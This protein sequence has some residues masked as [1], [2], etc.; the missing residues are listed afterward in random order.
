MCIFRKWSLTVCKRAPLGKRY[1]LESGT[2]TRRAESAGLL[3]VSQGV[4]ERGKPFLVPRLRGRL[5]EMQVHPLALVGKEVVYLKL[6]LCG[7]GDFDNVVSCFGLHRLRVN[8]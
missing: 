3:A 2:G 1:W 8:Q 4:V 6:V 5:P 7:V